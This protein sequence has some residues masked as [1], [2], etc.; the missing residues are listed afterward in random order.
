M[1]NYA[2]VTLKKRT[3]L[4]ELERRVREA[5]TTYLDDRW[6][7][8]RPTWTTDD[9]CVTLW[10]HIPGT[11]HED[12]EAS[13]R[14]LAP[15]QDVGFPVALNKNGRVITFR[16]GPNG[17]ESWAQGVMQEAL[18]DA[19]GCGCFYDATDETHPPG[20]REYRRGRTYRE[21]LLRNFD[22]SSEE[23]IA[24]VEGRFREITPEGFW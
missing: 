16:H 11:S 6:K 5:L 19:Y 24:W 20:S 2:Y 23:D 1:A 9:D 3:T 21:F 10:V 18:A 22:L 8:E 12:R 7:V 15:G 14:M 17:F 13:R 4:D